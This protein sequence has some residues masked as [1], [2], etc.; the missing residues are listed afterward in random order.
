MLVLFTTPPVLSP[1]WTHDAT[2]WQVAE[3]EDFQNI[4]LESLGDTENKLVKIFDDKDLDINKVYYARSRIVFNKG[5]AE[6]SNVEVIKLKDRNTINVTTDIPTLVGLPEVN[7][8]FNPNN[9][10]STFF[11]INTSNFTCTSNAK[12]MSTSYI[13]EDSDGRVVFSDLN[14]STNLT[15]LFVSNIVLKEGE[16]YTVKVTHESSSNDVSPIGM[17]TFTVPKI[18]EIEVLSDTTNVDVS[19][20]DY[21][22]KLKPIDDVKSINVKLYSVAENQV[23]ELTNKDSDVFTITLE[24]DLFKDITRFYI[25]SVTYTMDN[26]RIIG[27]KYIPLTTYQ[28]LEQE[29][30]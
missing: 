29:T 1:G 6:W 12:H 26:D 23:D 19:N 13:I 2:D 24:R 27:P 7:I 9:V 5:L 18:N 4:V 14:N 10:P 21:I 28:T 25:I 16:V 17:F 20:D 15:S 3:D 30:N 8:N 22:L 11:T